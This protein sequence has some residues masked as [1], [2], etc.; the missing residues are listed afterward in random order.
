[1]S[2]TPANATT[3]RGG[4]TDS[5][6]GLR[7]DADEQPGHRRTAQGSGGSIKK[8]EPKLLRVVVNLAHVI[9]VGC[10]ASFEE[11]IGA[12]RVIVVTFAPYNFKLDSASLGTPAMPR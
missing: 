7:S 8:A 5:E 4:R 12:A 11:A 10:R 2:R 9:T 6:A 3:G 1:V